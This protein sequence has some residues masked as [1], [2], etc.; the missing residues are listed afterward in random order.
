MG[1]GSSMP[2]SGCI[3]APCSSVTWQSKTVHVVRHIHKIHHEFKASVASPDVVGLFAIV[4]RAADMAKHMTKDRF[5]GIEKSSREAPMG[6]AAIY[7]HP[8]E[9]FAADLMCGA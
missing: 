6:L 2:T 7:C 3:S 5:S 4:Q 8:V 1:T 9:F